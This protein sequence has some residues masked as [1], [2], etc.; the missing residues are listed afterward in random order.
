[1]WGD[2]NKPEKWKLKTDNRLE[3]RITTTIPL[4]ITT[5]GILFEGMYGGHVFTFPVNVALVIS[6][7]LVGMA[8]L[9][10]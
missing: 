9:V 4:L 7:E 8:E 6:V 1:L 10:M 2:T 5:T 3:K